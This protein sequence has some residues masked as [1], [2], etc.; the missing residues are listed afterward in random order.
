MPGTPGMLSALSPTSASMSA[1]WRG[2]MFHFRRTAS[3]PSRAKA[4]FGSARSVLLVE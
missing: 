1:I 4:S 3:A 2:S